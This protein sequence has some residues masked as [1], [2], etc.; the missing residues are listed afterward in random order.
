MLC[1]ACEKIRFPCVNAKDRKPADFCFSHAGS[2][3]KVAENRTQRLGSDCAAS[4]PAVPE[5]EHR[6]TMIE[7]DH[8]KSGD[9]A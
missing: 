2:Q 3:R 8:V 5:G 6:P 1:D 7:A 9:A 4:R